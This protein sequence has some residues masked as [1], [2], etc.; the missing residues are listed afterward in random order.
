MTQ[1][2]A[3]PKEERTMT[4]RQQQRSCTLG[5][6]FVIVSLLMLL[7]SATISNA[8]T[9]IPYPPFN[10]QKLLP[11][12]KATLIQNYNGLKGKFLWQ[13]SLTDCLVAPIMGGD[14][15]WR[16]NLNFAEQTEPFKHASCKVWSKN[17]PVS[18][19]LFDW[20]WNHMDTTQ[21][22][23]WSVYHRGW[24]WL[25]PPDKD[26]FGAFN[27]GW[28]ET[29]Y[30]H[31]PIQQLDGAFATWD[32]PKPFIAF[33]LEYD[34]AMLMR[35]WSYVPA[36]KQ[37]RPGSFGILMEWK[38][39]PDGSTDTRTKMLAIGGLDCTQYEQGDMSVD[40][41]H[42]W[43]EIL[44]W[45]MADT[46]LARRKSF[47]P[48]TYTPTWKVSKKMNSKKNNDVDPGNITIFSD[49][50]LQKMGIAELQRAY[51][52]LWQKFLGQKVTG[53][54][55]QHYYAD[56]TEYTRPDCS[57]IYNNPYWPAE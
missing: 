36:E 5:V 49:S 40:F 34:Y 20:V 39:A 32:N 9:T 57:A 42:E 7:V 11:N 14:A 26:G 48:S 28:Q 41:P 44:S 33:P 54:F 8:C 51:D 47:D 31:G 55:L 3:K 38:T 2:T 52:A 4:Q 27:V 35:F 24:E 25:T 30:P 43:E 23:G 37:F 19:I 45:S 6:F 1:R 13:R 53:E 18:P 29:P 21:Y 22:E 56:H 12:P 10:V 15:D 46:E 17:V 50:E 16:N